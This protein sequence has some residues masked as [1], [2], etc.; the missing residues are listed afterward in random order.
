MQTA[1]FESEI[2]KQFIVQGD[3]PGLAGCRLLVMTRPLK[4]PDGVIQFPSHKANP[5]KLISP[6][7]IAARPDLINRENR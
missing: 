2:T 1:K 6:G 3:F 4:P 5:M 7:D